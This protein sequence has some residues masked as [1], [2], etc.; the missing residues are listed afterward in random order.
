M[1]NTNKF[2]TSGCDI[3][4]LERPRYFP[5]QL[6]TPAE[7]TQ[8]QDYFRQKQRLHN[9]L[10]H[11][12]GVVCGALVCRVPD[13]GAGSPSG[14]NSITNNGN[15]AMKPWTVLVKP[16]YILGPYGDDILIECAH[17]IDLMTHG[18][19]GASGEPAEQAL[20]PWCAEVNV[21][22]ESGDYYI[23]VKF[24]ECMTRPVRVQPVGCGCDETQCEYSRWRD[25]Y[26]IGIRKLDACPQ[27]HSSPP[28]I[29]DLFNGEM[30]PCPECATDPWVILAKVS[31]DENGLVGDPDNC[32]CRR[33][34]LA[35]GH[36]WWQCTSQRAEGI[37]FDHGDSTNQLEQGSTH[38]MEIYGD[39]QA[40]QS[41]GNILVEPP[42]DGP[43]NIVE[44]EAQRIEATV[45]I[46]ANA[47]P[48]P[49]ILRVIDVA[50]NEI[51]LFEEAMVIVVPG[52]GNTTTE[53]ASVMNRTSATEPARKTLSRKA[54]SKKTQKKSITKKKKG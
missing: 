1:R 10:L 17:E 9:R 14:A 7:M 12:W 51:R 44:I 41:G 53:R 34:V 13:V 38:I 27:N 22:R 49:R 26:E 46:G 25:G 54:L 20:D 21:A 30:P 15:G 2:G 11:G 50:G 31:V 29:D 5:R 35:F 6:I 52:G 33:N 4:L 40:M 47:D 28:D 45:T 48:G 23:A 19:S 16:G 42:I 37:V 24:K 18:L 8:E 32:A 39:W 36:Y 3:G 43:A